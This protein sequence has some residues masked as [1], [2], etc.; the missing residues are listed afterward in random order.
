MLG[1]YASAALICAASMLVG[2]A[3][4]TLAGRETWTWLEPVTGFGAILTV[5]G[6]L[7]RVVGHGTTATLGVVLLLVASIAV[8]RRAPKFRAPGALAAGLPVAIVVGLA[9]AI[10]FAVSGRWGIIGVGFNNDLGLHLAWAEWLRSG[11]GPEPFAGYPLGPHGLAVAVAAVPRIGLGQ[12]FMGE[13]FAITAMTGLTSL[14]ALGDLRPLRRTLAAA[15]VALTYLAASYFAQGAFKE[16][17]EALFVLGF[18]VALRNPAPLPAGRGRLL[19][20]SPYMAMAGGVFFAYSFAGLAWPFAVVGLWALTVPA[21]REALRPAALRAALLRRETLLWALGL[22]ALVAFALVGPFGFAE[23]LQQGRRHQHLRAGLPGRGARGL[24]GRELPARRAWRRPAD[25]AGGRDRRPGGGAGSNLVAAAAR[26]ARC[27]S[28]SAPAPLSTSSRS[29]FSGDYSQAKAL[30]IAAP[31]AMLRRDP[32]AVSPGSAAPGP[33]RLAGTALAVALRRRRRSTRPSSSSATLRSD[34]AGHGAELSAFLPIVH[35][36]PVLYAGQD[37][38]AAYELLG[39]DTH[40]PLVE[41]PDAEVDARTRKSRSTP[42]T[43]TAR[44][45][46]TRSH[47]GTLTASPT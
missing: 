3:L 27:R 36:K 24:A 5:T 19:A 17:A 11:Y 41:F 23:R 31:L 2:R 32:P 37:R 22:A 28:R 38:Y 45:T 16:T 39:A 35:G 40:V 29:P 12:A 13:I 25:R 44:S 8:V 20:L 6:I 7:S 18:A 33:R 10:P 43:P 9:L 1:T 15:M 34:L 26:P 46:S 47:A 4:L 42:A 30:M 14:A 21:V